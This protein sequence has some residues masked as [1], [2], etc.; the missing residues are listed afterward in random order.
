MNNENSHIMTTAAAN[1]N[2]YL[3]IHLFVAL[4]ASLLTHKCDQRF[5]ERSVNGVKCNQYTRREKPQKQSHLAL[6]LNVSFAVAA[7]ISFIA[8]TDVSV[9]MGVRKVVVIS[10]NF[11]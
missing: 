6:M 10:C 2:F 5:S 9:Q 11:A 8:V 1:V 4:F 3:W 7:C